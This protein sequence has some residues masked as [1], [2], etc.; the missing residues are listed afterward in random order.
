MIDRAFA[1]LGRTFGLTSSAGL[2]YGNL[3]GTLSALS[4][5]K[6]C[7]CISIYVGAHEEAAPGM[8]ESRTVSCANQIIS[9]IKAASGD[10]NVYHLLTD[11]GLEA[12]SL[13]NAGCVVAVNFSRDVEALEGIE[14]F[15]R[16][17][18]PQIAPLTRPQQCISCCQMT[19]G[20]GVPVKIDDAIVPM[21]PAC[22]E[23][24]VRI[25][26]EGTSL[27]KGICMA[28]L[29]ALV[30]GALYALL[31]GV[32]GY[33]AA[34]CTLLIFLLAFV[35]YTRF[36]GPQGLAKVLTLGV[37]T[38][39]VSML[40]AVAGLW[41]QLYE[42]YLSMNDFKRLG[43]P[44]SSGMKALYNFHSEYP[45]T[46]HTCLIISALLTLIC[47][48]WLIWNYR[49]KYVDHNRPRIVKGKI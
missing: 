35:G 43:L 44:A 26:T 2:M 49:M 40:S 4:S 30:G 11:D 25:G 38:A 20:Q 45:D 32:I 33:W 12:V 5:G 15:I 7:R 22:A 16:E 27:P 36:K 13:Q 46:L 1:A 42:R 8:Q 29:G 6:T 18:L 23:P 28:V 19:G 47:L 37:S 24:V 21:H 9:L 34:F 17:V 39:V 14:R 3:Q 41:P 31:Y 48:T 10:T